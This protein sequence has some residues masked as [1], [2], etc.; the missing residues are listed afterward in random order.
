[1]DVK[2]AVKSAK[3][4]V[5]E[6]FGEEGL[7]NVGLEEVEHDADDGLWRIT[8]GFSRPWNSV[9]NPWAAINGEPA[10]R[11]AYRVISLSEDGQMVSVKRREGVSE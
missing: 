4:Y 5:D 8:I 7:T 11:R 2:E 9:T 10:P 6:L 3:H 1:M